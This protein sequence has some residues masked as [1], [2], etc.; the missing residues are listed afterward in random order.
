MLLICERPGELFLHYFWPITSWPEEQVDAEAL[1]ELYRERGTAEGHLGELKS[2]LE[3]ALS[4]SPRPKN[5]YRVEELK[6]R[7]GSCD[8]FAHNEAILLLKK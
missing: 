5:H 6:K 4:S 3:S 2:V 1:L 7:Y 8:A